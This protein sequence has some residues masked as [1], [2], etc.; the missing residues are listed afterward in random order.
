LNYLLDTNVI[1]LMAPSKRRSGDAGRLAAWIIEHSGALWLSVVTA[2]EVESGIAKAVRTGATRKAR[3]LAEWWGEI[4]HYYSDR[5][6]PL[7]L[8]TAEET[9]RLL[10]LARAAGISP[11]FEDLAIAATGKRHGLA[12]LT[13]NDRDFRP[14]G[15]DVV[16]PLAA[17]P[18]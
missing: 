14:L 1:S 10:D 9:G 12:V 13:Q 11:G 7:D 5:I 18:D 8:E 6:L 4:R 16:N 15:I 2:A 3:N 17:L